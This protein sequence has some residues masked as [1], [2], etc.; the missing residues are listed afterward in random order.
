MAESKWLWIEPL[1]VLFFRDSKPFTAGE[2][3]RAKSAFPPTPYPF[4]GAIRSRVLADVLPQVGSNLDAYR[5]HITNRVN[6]QELNE[7]VTVLGDAEGY[8][9]L[10]FRG[11]FLA[12]QK[13]D[14]RYEFLFPA[15][16]DLFEKQQLNPLDKL[17]S[18][19]LFNPPAGSTRSPTLLW[20]RESLGSELKDV[21]LSNQGLRRYLQGEI[22]R[23]DERNKEFFW[24]ELRVGIALKPGRRTVEEGMFYMPEM[25]RLADKTGF[26]LEVAGLSFANTSINYN[27]PREGLLQL[28]GESRGAYYQTL[29]EGN[30]LS[31][32]EEL[33]AALEG[34]IQQTRRFK[35]YLASPAIFENG[36]LPDFITDRAKL[37]GSIEGLHVQLV[38]AAVGKPLPIGGWDLA[39]KRPKTM[40]KAVP[41]GSVYF[42]ELLEGD[43]QDAFNA[44]HFKCRLQKEAKD[45]LKELAK[46][47]FGLTFVG[48]WDYVKAK[49]G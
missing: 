3:F 4:V 36:W 40:Y 42:F 43:V 35:L 46:I 41:P 13:P 7:I 10:E 11:P 44:F 45:G 1:D 39:N 32:L 23:E 19:V 9:K 26:V 25:I 6:H 16:L 17:P 15:P 29:E 49:E 34:Q 18:G 37:E 28:G 31:K 14:K 47:G 27:F 2:S 38:A 30:P 20:S 48:C 33:G 8:G 21:F 22:P 12:R 24:R 5:E